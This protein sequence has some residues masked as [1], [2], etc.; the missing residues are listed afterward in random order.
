MI[1][2]S[3]SPCNGGSTAEVFV[4]RND[5][6]V[7]A[8]DLWLDPQQPRRLAF[9]SHAH[10]DHIARHDRILA[11]KETAR[12]IR[13][14]LGD[15]SIRTLEFGET[16]Q[17]ESGFEIRLHPAGHILGAAQIEILGQGRRLVYTGDFRLSP[18]ETTAPCA[19]VPCDTLIMECTFGKPNFVFPPRRQVVPELAA[20]IRR[21]LEERGT[22]V[23]LAY[24]LGRSQE[25]LK[26]LEPYEFDIVL[27]PTIY[28]MTQ[29]YEELGVRFGRYRM[30]TPQ[31]SGT[32]VLFV[33]PHGSRSRWVRRAP[34]P[35]LIAA[36][37]WTMNQ[38]H[39]PPYPADRCFP[40]SDHA[41]FVELN[42]YVEVAAPS[43]VYTLRGHAEF[44]SHLRARGV[45]AYEA[46]SK[47]ALQ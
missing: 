41:D 45:A 3:A 12:F 37:G 17:P 28:R 33:P 21:V 18:S 38:G 5:L 39:G 16:F 26:L 29:V 25:L 34:A 19:I 23:I 27:T 31:D 11:T 7:P 8:L 6:Y 40:I 32:F 22:P 35:V 47:V 30:A 46:E 10:G 42:R 4:Y 15:L 44:L 14:R 9:V 1:T 43:E 36:T 20:E 13:H 24:A 2:E